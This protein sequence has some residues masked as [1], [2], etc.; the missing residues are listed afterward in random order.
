MVKRERKLCLFM[1]KLVLVEDPGA[2]LIDGPDDTRRR[3]SILHPHDSTP[4]S[5]FRPEH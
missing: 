2:F 5:E 4:S 1:L 3:A